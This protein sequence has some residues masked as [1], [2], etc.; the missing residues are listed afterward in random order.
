MSSGN[1]AASSL[2]SPCSPLHRPVLC[3]RV[4]SSWRT[5]WSRPR[6]PAAPR[7]EQKPKGATA[8][9]RGRRATACLRWRLSLEPPGAKAAKECGKGRSM[10][11]RRPWGDEARKSFGRCGLEEA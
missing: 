3:S 5:P 7:I 2:T 10:P 9:A 11:R 4:T 8:R 1:L 6:P